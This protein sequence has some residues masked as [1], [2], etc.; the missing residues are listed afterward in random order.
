M[1]FMKKNRP[2]VMIIILLILWGIYET[3]LVPFE[4]DTLVSIF[5]GFN[6]VYL[7]PWCCKETSAEYLKIRNAAL[8]YAFTFIIAVLCALKIVGVL[9]ERMFDVD[10]LKMIFIGVFF[11]S[12]YFLIV[13]FKRSKV[14]LNWHYSLFY[15]W[16]SL[17]FFYG[18]KVVIGSLLP[19]Q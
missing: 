7:F 2:D 3:F 10:G 18:R 14:I 9:C 15:Y 13:K 8:Q 11:Q 19:L 17:P 12:V 16:D 5:I 6:L 4:Y 1:K